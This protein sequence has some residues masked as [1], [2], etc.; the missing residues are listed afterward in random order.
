MQ[1]ALFERSSKDKKDADVGEIYDFQEGGASSAIVK[2]FV[3]ICCMIPRMIS[4]VS[5]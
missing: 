4:W 5:P 2:V 3:M 1:T